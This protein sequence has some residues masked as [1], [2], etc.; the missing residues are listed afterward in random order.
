LDLKPD[1]KE[2]NAIVMRSYGGPEVLCREMVTSPRLA[3]DDIRVQ[4]RAAAVNHTDLKIRAGVW[5][6]GRSQPFPYVPG[7]EAAGVVTEVGPYVSKFH[8]GDCAITMMQG[9]GGVSAVR[10]GGYAEFV[11]GP[12]RNF[13]KLNDSI[14]LVDVATLGLACITAYN[15]LNQIGPMDGKD[16]LVTGAAGG[17]GSA[18]VALAAALGA[19]VTALVSRH[20]T[21]DYVQALGAEKVLCEVAPDASSFDGVLDTVSGP[22]FGPCVKSLKAHGTYSMVGAVAGADVA[23]DAWHLIT[24]VKLTGYSSENLSGDQLQQGID[25]ISELLKQGRLPV[26]VR[27]TFKLDDAAEAHT[28]LETRGTRGR[29][30]LVS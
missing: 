4:V 25:L 9:M 3:D 14:N 1:L 18:A 2:Y 15:G 12:S 5:P 8:V 17:V 21:I 19:R 11:S 20:S 16:I 27:T 28:V 30:L 22:L 10:Q 29:I 6:I 13:A 24:P 26:P 23:F 7:V